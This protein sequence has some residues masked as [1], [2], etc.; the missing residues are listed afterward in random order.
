[1]LIEIKHSYSTQ[2]N[3]MFMKVLC[4]A[5]VYSNY[6]DAKMYLCIQLTWIKLFVVLFFPKHSL[7]FNNIYQAQ[8]ALVANCEP[9]LPQVV[10]CK[11]SHEPNASQAK[12]CF[13][14]QQQ[15]PQENPQIH[16]NND[17]G[18]PSPAQHATNQCWLQLC[19]KTQITVKSVPIS[20]QSKFIR[21]GTISKTHA[22]IR[23]YR[24]WEN[25]CNKGLHSG[26]MSKCSIKMKKKHFLCQIKGDDLTATAH[27]STPFRFAWCLPSQ[28]KILILILN[29][30]FMTQLYIASLYFFDLFFMFHAQAGSSFKQDDV[31][32][33]K[34]NGSYRNRDLNLRFLFIPG[35]VENVCS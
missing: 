28:I 33:M 14:E 23:S 6:S 16:L 24:P 1:M 2:Q 34:L 13:L 9:Q 27:C 11:G 21:Y 8:Y 30:F 26:K 7:K 5:L 12:K 35:T 20:T 15:P 10:S 25:T 3:S 32:R 29:Y 17:T 31:W 4:S 22:G 18:N 19:C